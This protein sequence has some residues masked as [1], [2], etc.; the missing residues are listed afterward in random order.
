[1]PLREEENFGMTKKFPVF[2]FVLA[3]I[4]VWTPALRADFFGDL[5]PSLIRA[6]DGKAEP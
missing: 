4:L 6:K 1:M 5:S 3:L 2:V